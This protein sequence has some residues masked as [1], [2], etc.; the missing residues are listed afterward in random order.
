VPVAAPR[1]PPV[2]RRWDATAVAG[3]LALLIGGAWLLGLVGA[4][5]PSVES[6]AACL[7]IFLG[8]A[9]IVTART[10]WSLSRHSWPVW[11]GVVL[12]LTL[13]ATSSSYGIRGTLHNY[14]VGDMTRVA[15][16]SGTYYGGVGKLNVDATAAPAGAQVTVY[17]FAGQTVIDTPPGLPLRVDARVDGGNICVEGKQQGA[18]ALASVGSS[19]PAPGSGASASS[20]TAL[21]PVVVTVRQVA[22]QILIDGSGCD[23]R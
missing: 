23:H 6:V 7:L 16:G 18:G 15:T 13:V 11:A 19:F 12:V 21:A 14:S 8:V 2:R 17:S 5:H 20:G 1:L 9:S 10:D 4:A 3:T 22:G